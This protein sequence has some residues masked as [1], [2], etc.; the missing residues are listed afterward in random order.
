MGY[1]CDAIFLL[2]QPILVTFSANNLLAAAQ[3]YRRPGLQMLIFGDRDASGVGQ[4][5]AIEAAKAL[6]AAILFPP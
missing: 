3:P 1:W 2:N 5:S 6:R 4:R